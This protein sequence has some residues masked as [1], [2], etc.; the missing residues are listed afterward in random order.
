M[1]LDIFV[2]ILD[3]SLFLFFFFCTFLLTM[4]LYLLL[5]NILH[6]FSSKVYCV[7]RNGLVLC[8]L[9]FVSHSIIYCYFILFNFV[10][11][12]CNKRHVVWFQ[13]RWAIIPSYFKQNLQQS[14]SSRRKL[15]CPKKCN[16]RQ[17]N[18]SGKDFVTLR[19]SLDGK[20]PISSRERRAVRKRT[21]SQLLSQM[22]HQ[23]LLKS[24][25]KL[26]C[27]NMQPQIETSRKGIRPLIK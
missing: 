13:N 1:H 5:L 3:I 4:S 22:Q 23:Q 8:I 14:Q 20:R 15:L 9:S 26:L 19:F 7:L 10:S 6:I 24:W 2:D 17:I 16:H 18:P 25:R 27:L 21:S 11:C 12:C